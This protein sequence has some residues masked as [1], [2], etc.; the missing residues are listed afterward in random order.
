MRDAT[1]RICR[2]RRHN[3]II[4]DQVAESELGFLA[5]GLGGFMST[6]ILPVGSLNTGCKPVPHR[7]KEFVVE[8]FARGETSRRPS[9]N[10]PPTAICCH[11]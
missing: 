11:Y 4:F 3:S 6:G 8:G 5:S 7:A 10:L 9:Q 2:A 1:P